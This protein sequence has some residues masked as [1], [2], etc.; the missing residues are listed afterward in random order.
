MDPTPS[1]PAIA[2]FETELRRAARRFAAR[3]QEEHGASA[4]LRLARLFGFLPLGR[5]DLADLGRARRAAFLARLGEE[6]ARLVRAARR[7]GLGYDLNRHM[8][9]RRALGEVRSGMAD[10]AGEAAKRGGTA[11]SPDASPRALPTPERPLSG[12]ELNDRFRRRAPR[13]MARTARP[14]PALS[15]AGLPRPA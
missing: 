14:A 7:G 3:S 4:A 13:G 6:D 12:R 5:L 15:P 10:A 2:R 8:L 9:V 1:S 11:T